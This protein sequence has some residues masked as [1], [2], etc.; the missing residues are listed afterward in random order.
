[1]LRPITVIRC[2]SFLILVLSA[3]AVSAAQPTP[4]NIAYTSISPQ[5]SP[6]WLA[7]DAG[8]FR[9]N[10]IEAKLVYMRAWILATQAL[11]SNDVNFICAGGGGIPV[12][13]K[14]DG[15][16]A[17]VEAVV[18]K[19]LASALLARELNAD[20]LLLLTDVAGVYLDWGS[21]RERLVARAGPGMLDHR[22]FPPG[23]I[24]PKLQ[25]ANEFV[26]ATGKS[27]SIGRLEDA[28]L[29]VQGMAGTTVEASAAERI[30]RS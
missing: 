5:Y 23:S 18:D 26:A 15:S 30:L 6:V 21:E 22:L 16:F 14:A 27:A 3:Q 4:I 28:A 12:V 1:M 9:K 8:I 2:W 29:I 20:H 13:H 19:D 25:A 11:V 7:N 10:G 24:G 17:G